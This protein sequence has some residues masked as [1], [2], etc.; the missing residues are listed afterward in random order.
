MF[1]RKDIE[2]YRGYLILQYDGEEGYRV[3][4]GTMR[5]KLVETVEEARHLVDFSLS[6]EKWDSV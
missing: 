2:T 6:P 4:F 5:S 1:D 3:D